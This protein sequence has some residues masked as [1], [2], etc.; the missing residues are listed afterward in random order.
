MPINELE[1]GVGPG[2]RR[3]EQH[4]PPGMPADE[5][6]GLPD[7][8]HE[9]RLI[10]DEMV[11]WKHGD[12]GAG[13]ASVDPGRREEDASGR[14]PIARLEQ[15]NPGHRPVRELRPENSA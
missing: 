6:G 15:Q 2:R 11:G 13:G 7:V 10:S 5:G 8:S 3:A 4:D 14:P 9:S 1:V 12:R